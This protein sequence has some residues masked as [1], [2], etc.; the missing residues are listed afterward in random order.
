MYDLQ[1]V[2]KYV[3]RGA[4]RDEIFLIAFNSSSVI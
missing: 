2:K 1:G 3:F 4:S